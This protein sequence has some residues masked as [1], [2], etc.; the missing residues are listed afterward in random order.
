MLLTEDPP[1]LDPS[2]GPDSLLDVI[3]TLA[4]IGRDIASSS[5]RAEAV[6]HQ[7]AV[8]LQHADLGERPLSAHVARDLCDALADGRAVAAEAHA[9]AIGHDLDRLH[10]VVLLEP[11]PEPDAAWS[12]TAERLAARL[13]GIVGGALCDVNADG[14]RAL[15]PLRGADAASDVDRLD[16]ALQ[17]LAIDEG[18]SVGRSEVR[19][20]AGAQ[21]RR[22]FTEAGCAVRVARAR[23]PHG[24][25][26][27]YGELGV[28]RYLAALPA[29]HAPDERHADAI[30]VLAAYDAK[31]RTELLG[32][33]E[34]HLGDRGALAA[35]ARALYIH[36]NPLR[37]RLD[38]IEQLTGLVLADEDLLSLELALKLS[39]LQPLAA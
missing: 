34:R 11:G 24:G 32:T 37:Q 27:A 13:S 30:A 31:R 14:V 5:R 28:Y 12:E 35:T 16:L 15:V 36:T 25:A 2:T 20:A 21:A 33:L 10:V 6:G 7:L 38:R 4:E 3:G 1:V 8:A 19:P 9:R 17:Q 39:R 22:G 18:V 23:A 26:R 29:E